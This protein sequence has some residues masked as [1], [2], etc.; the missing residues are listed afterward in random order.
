[1]KGFMDMMKQA[2]SL[3]SK[4]SDIQQQ[5]GKMRIEGK[6]GAGMVLVVMDG[7]GKLTGITIDPSLM[8]PDEVEILEDL[9]TAAHADAKIKLEQATSEKMQEMTG[10]L[11]LP[12]G[13][14]LF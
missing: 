12:E 13:M 10:G 3:Q 1:M 14:K 8:K 7:H 4:M 2:Q 5:M 11:Q 6:A 9:I